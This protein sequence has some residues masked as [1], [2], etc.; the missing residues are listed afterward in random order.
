MQKRG[1]TFAIVFGIVISSLIY[2]I[3]VSYQQVGN[4]TQSV[5]TNT[6]TSVPTTDDTNTTTAVPTTDDI[7]TTAS[8][9]TTDNANTTTAVPTTIAPQAALTNVIVEPSNSLFFLESHYVIGFTTATTGTIK[10]ITIT[11]PA[12]FNIANA[13]LIEASGI[14]AGGISV[15][16]QTLTY[17]V[18]SAVSV[19]AGK[20]IMIMLG[21]IVNSGVA[22]NTVSITTKDATN[23]VIDGPSASLPFTLRSVGPAML[24]ANSVT[25]NNIVNGT[26]IRPDI[27]PAAVPN[28]RVITFN[29]AP[30]ATS[31][32]ILVP[33]IN[34]AVSV[35][36][37]QT[38]VGDRGVGQVSLL[39]V[40]GSFLEW[41]GIESPAGA[42]LTSGFNSVAGTHIVFI[43]FS[44]TL[45]IEVADADHIQI[46]NSN[47]GPMAGKI[48]LMW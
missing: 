34:Q 24:G 20:S 27:A 40:S 46:H 25:T 44:H 18:N 38:N 35:M 37:V 16:G 14:G 41:T 26:I 19:P 8:V 36:G 43:D 5:D 48:T 10:V 29:L 28:Y 17:T 15:A 45:D 11:F 2:F 7:S 33:V 30:G 13:K 42:A 1:W 22:S 12:G 4:N 31:A 47:P 32:P 6:A 23:F 9:P 3:P 39:R 21:K